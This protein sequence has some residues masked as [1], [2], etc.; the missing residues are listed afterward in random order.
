[1]Y[2]NARHASKRIRSWG[3]V[4]FVEYV[5]NVPGEDLGTLETCPTNCATTRSSPRRLPNT[6]WTP[7]FA[8]STTSGL[9]SDA[10]SRWRIDH[11]AHQ[12][13]YC[14]S[15]RSVGAD[16]CPGPRTG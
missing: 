7:G 8:G 4:Q 15:L 16:P 2:S 6:F 13:R 14:L 11:E 10:A 5:F 3:V 12:S 1:S 9:Q